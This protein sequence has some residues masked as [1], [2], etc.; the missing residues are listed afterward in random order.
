MAEPIQG[1]CTPPIIVVCDGEVYCWEC[2]CEHGH[3]RAECNYLF[4]SF[5]WSFM[6]SCCKCTAHLFVQ[7][8]AQSPPDVLPRGTILEHTKHGHGEVIRLAA[9]GGCTKRNYFYQVN[10]T[11][12]VMIWFIQ[13]CTVHQQ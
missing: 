9:I 12:A 3:E 11:N 13:D 7:V 8:I 10:C 5:P 6:P 1:K 4:S 2:W